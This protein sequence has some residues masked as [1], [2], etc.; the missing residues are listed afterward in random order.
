MNTVR[1]EL[2]LF[3]DF[4][5]RDWSATLIPGL[6]VATG[7]VKHAS[8]PAWNVVRF[9]PWVA[10]Y[11][12]FFNLSSQI[13]S[14]E[15][16]R[17]NKPDRPLPSGKIT[18]QGAKRRWA[19]ALA[20]L[21]CIALINGQLM[22]ETATWVVTTAFLCLTSYGGHWFGKNIV[23]MCTGSWALLGGIYKTIARPAETEEHFFLVVSIWVAIALQ[24]QDL[25]DIEGDTA[26]GRKTLPI[27]VGDRQSR[28]LISF[29]FLPLSYAT[30]WFGGVVS[31]A[32]TTVS[33][34]HVLLA[35]RTLHG[36][37][38]NYDHKTY[39]VGPSVVSD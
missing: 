13:V 28:W 25:R 20:A 23:A 11:I 19:I 22:V 37:E 21:L 12:Y 1:R 17:I 31:L 6:I 4:T 8:L 15:E 33:A 18:V 32:P 14:I 24:I 34:A 5:W 29:A 30:L 38:A 10:C 39:M 27:V 9:I 35:Y 3:F 26:A 7:A 36:T 2:R 16:D